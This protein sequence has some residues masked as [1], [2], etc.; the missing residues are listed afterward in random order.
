MADEGSD[1]HGSAPDSSPVA[2]LLVDVINDLEF[3][4]GERLL[5]HAMPMA[6]ALARLKERARERGVPVIYVNDNF[7]RWQ[8][9]FSRTVEHVLNDGCRGRPITE[10]LHPSEHDY[11]VLKPK[12]SGFFST[13]LQTLLE[14]LGTRKLIVTG[15]AAHI[16]VLFTASDAYMR[17]LAVVV[18]SDCVAS[19]DPETKRMALTLMEDVLR[20]DTTPSDRLDLD[21]MIESARQGG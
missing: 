6:R 17:D 1:L 4:G 14:H 16:C 9:D 13:T 2:L 10:L 5:E 20:A 7:G 8:S 19:P 12:H 11:F 18:P 21:E 15:L 3:E